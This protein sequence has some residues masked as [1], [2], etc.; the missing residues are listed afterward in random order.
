MAAS[1]NL[2]EKLRIRAQAAKRMPAG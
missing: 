1:G 2:V